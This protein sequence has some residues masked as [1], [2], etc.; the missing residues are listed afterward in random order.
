MRET[1]SYVQRVMKGTRPD[2][3]ENMAAILLVGI[4]NGSFKTRSSSSIGPKDRVLANSPY[5]GP[6]VEDGPDLKLSLALPTNSIEAIF[7]SS[8]H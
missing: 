3:E 1:S 7:S 5:S 8:S 4:A 2:D 6:I